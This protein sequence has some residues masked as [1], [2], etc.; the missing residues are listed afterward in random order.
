MSREILK[1]FSR[2]IDIMG[3][4]VAL[5]IMVNGFYFLLYLQSSNNVIY[6]TLCIFSIVFLPVYIMIR[7]FKLSD[8]VSPP[9]TAEEREVEESFREQ[10]KDE[11]M[12]LRKQDFYKHFKNGEYKL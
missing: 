5:T 10:F 4:A 3:F 11:Y 12:P 9:P 8:R 2:L 1:N 6:N 7:T